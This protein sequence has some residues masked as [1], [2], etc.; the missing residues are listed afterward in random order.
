MS[1]ETQSVQEVLQNM[2]GTILY[3]C[4]KFVKD[5]IFY[6]ITH[7]MGGREFGKEYK[8]TNANDLDEY[9]ESLAIY[10]H[11]AIVNGSDDSLQCNREYAGDY[12]K[13]LENPNCASKF[14][15]NAYE[16]TS[17][18]MAMFLEAFPVLN[19]FHADDI[20]DFTYEVGRDFLKM[21]VEY[22]AN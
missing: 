6:L 12:G 3:K 14:H 4:K 17:G 15:D 11:N 16:F 22:D 5:A 20:D 9:I 18:A 21:V 2:N 10:F 8:L 1:T 19:S 13:T 7:P